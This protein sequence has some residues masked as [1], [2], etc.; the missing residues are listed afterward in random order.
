M[1]KTMIFND[2]NG[3]DYSATLAMIRNILNDID[4]QDKSK[5][6]LEFAIQDGVRVMSEYTARNEQTKLLSLLSLKLSN[7][8][9]EK[10]N[11]IQDN[12]K[13][14]FLLENK[15]IDIPHDL[16]LAG[17][18]AGVGGIDISG[19][20]RGADFEPADEDIEK[21]GDHSY[22]IIRYYCIQNRFYRFTN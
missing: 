13:E 11:H 2:N 6:L 10:L 18:G 22:I 7:K 5:I 4:I 19:L 16:G 21:K 9:I 12:G 20:S 1:I 8:R 14:K 15:D 17:P 3:T